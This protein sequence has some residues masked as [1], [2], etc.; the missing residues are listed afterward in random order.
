LTNTLG[1]LVF[2]AGVLLR[3]AQQHIACHS[4]WGIDEVKSA[5]YVS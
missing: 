5:C 1:R 4:G 3:F 2:M